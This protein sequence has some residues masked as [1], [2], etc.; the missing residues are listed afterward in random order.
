MP[1]CR[2]SGDIGIG[3]AVGGWA[4]GRR[5]WGAREGEDHVAEWSALKS[6]TA[7]PLDPLSPSR[8][9]LLWCIRSK[10][11]SPTFSSFGDAVMAPRSQ[12]GIWLECDCHFVSEY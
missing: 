8:F 3:V 11:V 5:V 7:N 9:C 6:A 4:G 10:A 12:S 2:R 1:G